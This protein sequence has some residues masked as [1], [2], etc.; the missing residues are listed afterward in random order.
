MSI[1][2]GPIS[3]LND[4]PQSVRM[5][6]QTYIVSRNSDDLPIILSSECPHQGGTVEVIDKGCLQCPRHKWEFD[7]ETGDV[8]NVLN[9]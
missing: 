5:D 1:R 4:L 6:G 7:P 9:E 2:I 8:M 3:L